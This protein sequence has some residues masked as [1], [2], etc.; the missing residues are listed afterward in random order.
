MCSYQRVNNSYSCHNSKVLNG[1][2]KTELGFQGFVVSDWSGQHTGTA[3]ALAGLDMTMPS[4]DDYWGSQLVEAVRNG[5]VPERSLDDKATRVIAAWYYSRQD[6]PNLPPVAVG[7]PYDLLGPHEVVDARDP[8]DA[9]TLLEGAIQGHVL[10]KNVDNALPL[11]KPRVLTVYGYDAKRPE[12]NNPNIGSGDWSFG[13]ESTTYD[14][15][16][17]GFKPYAGQCS[18]PFPAFV[19]G[20]IVS[21]GGSGA[22]TPFYI[23]SPIQALESRARK[24]GTQLFWDLENSNSTVPG[25]TD[26]CLV[27]TNAYSSEGVDR[28]ALRDDYSDALV[29]N[30]AGQCEN[31]IVVIHNAGIR[32]VDQWIDHPNVTAV[33]LAQLPGQDS[34]EAITQILYGDVSPSGKLPYTIARNESDYGSLLAPKTASGWDRYFPQDNFTEGVFIDYRAFDENDIQPRF[35]FGFGLTYT[36]FKYSNLQIKNTVDP[37]NLSKLPSGR[38]IPGGHEDLWDTVATVIADATNTGDVQ[39]AEAGQLYVTIP[40]DGQPVRQLRGFDKVLLSPGETKS[41][42]FELRRRDLSV[43]DVT[44]QQWTLLTGSDYDLSVGASSRQ[45]LLNGTLS[46]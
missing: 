14:A 33:V 38:V 8:D 32:L 5:S 28:V 42:E 39:A 22:V 17:C 7:L 43:W 27:F 35:E 29:K 20:T 21:G 16:K 45:L 26:A 40:G 15:V 23:D 11:S 2:L 34:G 3:S 37:S 25:A 1:L 19:N 4:G 12:R 6:D 41:F 31:T 24:E 36:T 46:L 10:V 9:D 30:I 18:V 44:A 13:L